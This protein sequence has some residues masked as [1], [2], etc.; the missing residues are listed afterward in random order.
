MSSMMVTTG[1]TAVSAVV[2]GKNGRFENLFLE[3]GD[4]RFINL[5]SPILIMS[6][7]QIFSKRFL[8][9]KT[10]GR[11]NSHYNIYAAAEAKSP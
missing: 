5:Q 9:I 1:K 8:N 2:G 4:W 11:K 6:I 7:T 3:I 10:D